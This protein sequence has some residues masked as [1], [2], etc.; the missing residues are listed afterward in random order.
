MRR[1]SGSIAASPV[2]LHTSSRMLPSSNRTFASSI[3][4]LEAYGNGRVSRSTMRGDAARLNNASRA[5]R[6]STRGGGRTPAASA[7]SSGSRHGGVHPSTPT[8]SSNCGSTR[9]GVEILLGDRASGT[10]MARIVADDGVD[11]RAR[12]V[13]RL[14]REQALA[15]REEP[16]EAGFLCHDGPAGCEITDAAIAEP[17]AA[18]RGVAA[19][20]H[21]DLAF[22]A[23]HERPIAVRCIRHLRRID[24][25]PAVRRQEREVPL[26]RRDEWPAPPRTARASCRAAT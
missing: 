10:R 21:A 22:R 20:G 23:L 1:A 2:S 7:R 13:R 24:Q 26:S 17:A 19:L 4:K 16:A 5:A 18:R 14:E 12:L 11:P 3:A 6:S 9:D 15:G 25:R 8:R